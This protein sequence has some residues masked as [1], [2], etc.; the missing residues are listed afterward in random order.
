VELFCVTEK[1]NYLTAATND[2]HI[3]FKYVRF[4]MNIRQFV[5]LYLKRRI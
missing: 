4:T 2:L 3:L 5:A 1:I